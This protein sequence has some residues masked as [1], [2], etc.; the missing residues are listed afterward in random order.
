MS[1]VSPSFRNAVTRTLG[2]KRT[3]KKQHAP[4]GTRERNE[5]VRQASAVLANVW[6]SR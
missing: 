2:D 1:R 4:K 3:P 6:G 5:R